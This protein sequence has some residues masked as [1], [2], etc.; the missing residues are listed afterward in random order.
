MELYF[1]SFF[2]S[3]R[4]AA[5]LFSLCIVSIWDTME[6]CQQISRKSV[7]EAAADEVSFSQSTRQYSGT[8]CMCVCLCVCV[9]VCMCV[10]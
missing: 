2:F 10:C 1:F 3:V 4:L 6:S 9:C 8:L 7:L 5:P